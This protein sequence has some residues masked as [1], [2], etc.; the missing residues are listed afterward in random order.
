MGHRK[1]IKGC[2]WAP[3]R[4]VRRKNAQRGKFPTTSPVIVGVQRERGKNQEKKTL[5]RRWIV[6][7]GVEG[8]DGGN[9]IEALH[10]LL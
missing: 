6:P 1:E 9:T 5:N 2:V 7:G 3:T 10:L 8:E 4:D